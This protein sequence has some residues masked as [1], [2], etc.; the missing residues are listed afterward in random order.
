MKLPVYK[1]LLCLLG[2]C[3]S[4][5][6][7]ATN[8]YVNDNATSGDVFTTAIGNDANPGSAAAPFGTIQFAIN[9][10]VNGDTIYVDAGTYIG[11]VQITKEVTLLGAKHGIPAG[12]MATPPNRGTD[13]TIIQAGGLYY[14]QTKDNITVDGFYIDIGSGLRGIESR[15][16]NSK[17]LNNIVTGIVSPF[18]AQIGIATRANAPLRTHSYLIQFNNVTNLRYG[19]FFD[20][21]LENPSEMSYNYASGCFTAGFVLTASNGHL[22]KA[23]VSD[24]N[25]QGLLV[26]K[27]NNSI[28]QN[29]LKNNTGIGIRLSGT[30]NTFNNDIEN[31][32]I[33]NN[34]VGIGLTDPN[35][36]AVNNQAHFNSFTGNTANIAN[37]HA[38]NFNA[39]CNWY[40]TTDLATITASIT[41]PVTFNPALVSGTDTDPG[42][43]GF[44]PDPACNVLPVV[45]A[46]FK[47]QIK[48]Q[49]PVLS[50]T[51]EQEINSDHFVLERSTDNNRF[52]PIATVAAAGNSSVTRQYQHT[53]GQP[54]YNQNLYYRLNMVDRDGRQQYS[55]VVA[56]KV[57]ANSNI[58]QNIYPNPVQRNQ[59]VSI[60]Y[61]SAYTQPANI[62]LVNANGQPVWNGRINLLKGQSKLEWKVPSV[63]AG[64]YLLRLQAGEATEQQTLLIQ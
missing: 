2:L 15:G 45:L 6:S 28:I 41:G 7:M 11:D 12:P 52:A 27:G 33:E 31:N 49:Q 4:Q 20:G 48:N 47:G 60:T 29:T 22:F 44:Q 51:T 17:I 16:L 59:A 55:K 42:T 38:D 61:V 40:G 37:A 25:F 8:W 13:E 9:T 62:T 32:F 23:N 1:T 35:A 19:F 64:L 50:W 63:A 21:N 54:V 3:Y 43:D 39:T 56:L 34:A 26:T 36:A 57:N 58:I 10:A 53:D 14:G 24:N 46:S 5:A 30:V 18:T